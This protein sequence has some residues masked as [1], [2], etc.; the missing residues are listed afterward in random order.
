MQFIY[1][2]L[3]PGL[4]G[5]IAF[6]MARYLSPPPPAGPFQLVWL[7]CVLSTSWVAG[8]AAWIVMQPRDE[9]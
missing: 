8:Y 9:D 5:C 3:W 2:W 6:A 4:A 1:E 7:L